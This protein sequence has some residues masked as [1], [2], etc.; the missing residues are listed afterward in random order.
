MEN[1]NSQNEYFLKKEA[2]EKETHAKEA[3]SKMKKIL[4]WVVILLV[5]GFVVWKVVGSVINAPNI[6]EVKGDFFP[7]QSREQKNRPDKD[8]LHFLFRLFGVDF[9][10]FGFFFQKILVL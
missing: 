10:V 6:V 1:E 4:V 2:K 7:A 5:V 3:K 9:L 8:F